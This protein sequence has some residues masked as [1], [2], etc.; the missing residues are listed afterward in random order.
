MNLVVCTLTFFVLLAALVSCKPIGGR[1]SAP[2]QL[3]DEE[4]GK[5]KRAV[6][7]VPGGFVSPRSHQSKL[8]RFK[9]VPLPFKWGKRSGPD[10]SQHVSARR[11]QQQQ[12]QHHNDELCK[13][14]FAVLVN[15]HRPFRGGLRFGRLSE[16][17]L[18]QLYSECFK[19][20][21]RAIL[22]ENA[23]GV[24][25]GSFET[26]DGEDSLDDMM[27]LSDEEETARERIDTD[28]S[29]RDEAQRREEASGEKISGLSAKRSETK[30]KRYNVPFR[31][32][33]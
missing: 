18:E 10:S 32:G 12:Q 25:S 16:L 23:E 5:A 30:L 19:E 26:A 29:G 21:A 28:N 9:S 8:K 13:E 2:P 14:M 24:P 11:Q 20:L 17:E 3:A 22:E 33:K 15:E 1:E 27:N 7:A 31:W 6:S 4:A